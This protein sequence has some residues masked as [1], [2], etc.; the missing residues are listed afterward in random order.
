M[1]T[2]PLVPPAR[3]VLP[4]WDRADAGHLL[5]AKVCRYVETPRCVVAAL[6]RG[7]VP[8]AF[9]IARHLGAPL[10]LLSVRKVGLPWQPELALA[11]VASG[12]IT[13]VD[14]ELMHA[15]RLS[16][17]VVQNLIAAKVRDLEAY[18]SALRVRH[19]AIPLSGQSVVLVDD[20]AATGSTMLAAIASA[21]DHKAAKIIVAV[22][23]A[24]R[25][26]ASQL[27]RAADEF[28]CLACPEHFIAVGEWYVS[29]AQVS[30]E[31]VDNLL[32][33]CENGVGEISPEAGNG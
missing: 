28:V 25:E 9:E 3:T 33:E 12:G 14:R 13:I 19:P 26:A 21:R 6:P 29:F 30:D 16:E 27:R 1:K 4:L 5:A 31:I 15:C 2:A 8:V 17:P 20:G 22:P 11:A 24:S 10:D 32:S 7:G 18:E 23:V